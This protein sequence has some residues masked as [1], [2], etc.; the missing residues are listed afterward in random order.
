MKFGEKICITPRNFTFEFSNGEK[1][2]SH[3]AMIGVA[4]NES[5]PLYFD[6]VNE[7]G[8]CMAGL[9]FPCNAHYF[10]PLQGKDNVASFEF[11]P[12][13][14]SQC[15]DVDDAEKLID[16][17][18]I[19]SDSFSE[20]LVATPLHWII[21]DKKKALTAESVASGLNVYE[22]KYGVLTN[23][24]PFDRQCSLLEGCEKYGVKNY[25]PFDFTFNIIIIP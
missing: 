5:M 2:T 16:N 22:N 1:L 8:L 12:W 6:A 10:K 14:L 15:D 23:E 3:Y 9:N 20:K 19:T 7:K 24:P 25:S 4:V 18:N 11:I 13:I 17:V 21:A